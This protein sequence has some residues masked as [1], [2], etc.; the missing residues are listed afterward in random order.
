MPDA[1]LE[2]YESLAEKAVEVAAFGG[3]IMPQPSWG[4]DAAFIGTYIDNLRD[5]LGALRDAV[6]LLDNDA[7]RTSPRPC[8]TCAAVTKALA[9]PF[10]CVAVAARASGE[11]A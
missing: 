9:E 2:D 11:G 7:H 5:E 4:Q 8:A 3:R 6:R 10:G 1:T